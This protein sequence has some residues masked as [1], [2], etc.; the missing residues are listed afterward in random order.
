[1][2]MMQISTQTDI[3]IYRKSV[4]TKKSIIFKKMTLKFRNPKS[5]IFLQ[6]NVY[7]MQTLCNSEVN[8]AI[9]KLVK[10]AVGLWLCAFQETK[11]KPVKPKLV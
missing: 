1:M 9:L 11:T 6:S 8:K 4:A 5:N 7:K 2:L 10:E 3:Y